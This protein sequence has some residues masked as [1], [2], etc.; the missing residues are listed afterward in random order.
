MAFSSFAAFEPLAAVEVSVLG[1]ERLN[2]ELSALAGQ[3]IGRQTNYQV[4]WRTGRDHP[5]GQIAL[6][7]GDFAR[8]ALERTGVTVAAKAAGPGVKK[9]RLESTLLTPDLPTTL[10]GNA[11]ARSALKN[12]GFK[13]QPP[14]FQK[15]FPLVPLVRWACFPLCVLFFLLLCV[16]PHVSALLAHL[17]GANAHVVG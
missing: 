9:F 17:A 12:L 6:K 11:V 15:D 10:V 8:V 13:V 5:A 16:S 4:T 14:Q 7:T 1:S 3:P 2:A